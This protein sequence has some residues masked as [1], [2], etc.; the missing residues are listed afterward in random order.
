MT[1]DHNRVTLP[2]DNQS[3]RP[4][5]LETPY[6]DT[7]IPTQSQTKPRLVIPRGPPS[8]KDPHLNRLRYAV[9]SP[10]PLRWARPN[11]SMQIPNRP[12]SMAPFQP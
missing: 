3:R 6:A 1:Q 2:T 9:N 5:A 12:E 8:D 11:P 7:G 10:E 4:L